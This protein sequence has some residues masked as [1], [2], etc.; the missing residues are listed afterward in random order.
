MIIFWIEMFASMSF[1]V[2]MGFFLA[3]ALCAASKADLKHCRLRRKRTHSA[4]LVR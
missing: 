4:K 1:G 3:A 2:L